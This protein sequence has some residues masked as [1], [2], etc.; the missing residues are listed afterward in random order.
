MPDLIALSIPLFLLLIGG[1]V[2]LARHQGLR[3]Y[4][5][6][7]AVGDL[8]CGIG[9]QLVLVLAGGALLA[10]YAGIYERHRLLELPSAWLQWAVALLGVDFLYYWWHRASHRMTLMWAVHVVHHQSEDYN[11]AVAL[12]QA[13]LSGFTSLPFFLPLA[14][15]GVPPLVYLAANGIDTLYQFWIH[16]QLVGRL[17]PLERVLNTPSH[18]RVHHAVNREYLDK[19]Y[20]GILIVWDRLFGTFAEEREQPVYGTTKPFATFNPVWAQVAYFQEL[21]QRARALPRWSDRLRVLAMP[22]DWGPPETGT[23]QAAS[24][25]ARYGR[26][27]PRGREIYAL[28]QLAPL[29]VATFLLMLRSSALHP[30]ATVAGIGLVLF[31]LLSLGGLLDG[32]RWAWPAEVARL[33]TVAAVGAAWMGGVWPAALGG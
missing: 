29:I 31:S 9:Q 16:T 26:E 14:L 22:P 21:W 3:V 28:L 13:I 6:A 17:G 2:L 19:N 25:R 30:M 24:V 1:E 33:G 32:R 7:D 18:H 12:R 20:G 8:G 5:V 27:V 15:L 4:R 11:L 23:A 10:V